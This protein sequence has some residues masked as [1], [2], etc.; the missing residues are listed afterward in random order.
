M[1]KIAFIPARGNSKGIKDKNIALLAGKPLIYWVCN[2]LQNSKIDKIIVATDSQTI[3]DTV[4]SFNFN[5]LEVYDRDPQNA[6]DSSPT[7]DVVIEYF[8]KNTHN[9]N[10][11]FCLVQTTSPLLTTEDIDNVLELQKSST[12]VFSG[13]KFPRMCW[14]QNGQPINHSL[15]NRKRRQDM[16][17]DI[18]VENG[19]IYCNTIKEIKESNALLSGTI[20]PYIM[21]YETITEIDEPN[22]LITVEHILKQKIKPNLLD[23]K[24]LITDCDGVLTDGGMY[25]SEEGEALKKFNTNDGMGLKLIQGKNLYV[26]IV[27]GENT[28]FAIERAKKLNIDCYAGIHNKLEKIKEI[29]KN[30]NIKLS[31]IIY[32]GDDLND[33]DV[34][35]NVGYSA[36]PNNAQI[37]IKKHVNYISRTTGGNGAVREIINFLI[38][39]KD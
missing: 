19:A 21:P 15:K 24:A 11:I 38:E 26:S 28:K 17:D 22:D 3:K 16:D 12:S 9:D 1:S 31:E 8:D 18:V 34:I 29:A 5:K 4:L 37:E 35:K 6:Q 14:T 33:L 13:V 2:S 39:E 32:I 7:I 30:K 36:C 20:K 23:F 27:T 10:D 25:Y